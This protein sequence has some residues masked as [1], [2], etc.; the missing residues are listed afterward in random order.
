MDIFRTAQWE[1]PT[2]PAV[3]TGPFRASSA[4]PNGQRTATRIEHRRSLPPPPT[5]NRLSLIE[6]GNVPPDRRRDYMTRNTLHRDGVSSLPLP[7]GYEQRTTQQGQVY[8]LHTQTGVST[9]HDP[10]IPRQLSHINGDDLGQLPPGWEM[11][12]TSTGR[13]YYVDHSSR[14]TQFTDPRIRQYI[15]R[16]QIRRN[17]KISLVY[18]HFVFAFASYAFDI[19][20]RQVSTPG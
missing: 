6:S 14:T 5:T 1:R 12:T 16:L 19:Q 17:G 11:R 15:D 13:V 8:F 4:T 18:S 3:P 7:E 2:R 10:R 9:W 20:N